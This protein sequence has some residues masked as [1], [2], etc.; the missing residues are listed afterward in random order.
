M[1]LGME[2]GECIPGKDLLAA[3]FLQPQSE[4]CQGG[5]GEQQRVP[6]LPSFP[7]LE[8]GFFL[9]FLR[10]L[11]SPWLVTAPAPMEGDEPSP[12]GPYNHSDL[13]KVPWESFALAASCKYGPGCCV[14]GI[15][16]G[17]DLEGHRAH[18]WCRGC[19]AAIPCSLT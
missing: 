12:Q 17:R 6:S 13:N 16:V 11:W 19:A 15:Q 4:M 14:H 2:K 18:G 8:V 1:D 5:Q 7:A 9:L 3:C 10:C